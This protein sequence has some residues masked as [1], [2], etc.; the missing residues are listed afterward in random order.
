MACAAVLIS[1]RTIDDLIKFLKYKTDYPLYYS[2]DSYCSSI[3]SHALRALLV[4]GVMSGQ[5]THDLCTKQ[6][7]DIL[8]E[9]FDYMFEHGGAEEIMEIVSKFLKGRRGGGGGG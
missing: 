7:Y 8:L 1:L 9:E 5:L 4:D 3:S 2:F 6:V